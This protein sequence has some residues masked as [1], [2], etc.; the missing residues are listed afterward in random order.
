METRQL[1][2]VLPAL[3]V[4]IGGLR[5]VPAV[6]VEVAIAVHLVVPAAAVGVVAVVAAAAAVDE[7]AGVAEAQAR[8]GSL[9]VGIM[10]AALASSHRTTVAKM[11]FAM[12]Q[13]LQTVMRCQRA[14]KSNMMSPTMTADRSTAPKT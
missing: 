8:P 3:A 6:A 10:I 12:Y 5:V 9:V 11:F 14:K 2:V 13:Q 1:P 7:A 4:K